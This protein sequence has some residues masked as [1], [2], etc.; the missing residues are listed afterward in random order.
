MN[1]NW[2]PFRQVNS[3]ERQPDRR[4][5]TIF[6]RTAQNV[7]RTTV[8]NSLTWLFGK[9]TPWVLITFFLTGI[10]ALA[11]DR[12]FQAKPRTC[13]IC[14]FQACVNGVED[15]F[16][17]IFFPAI[18]GLHSVSEDRWSR[19]HITLP[20]H[21]RAPPLSPSI[22]TQQTHV[23]KEYGGVQTLENP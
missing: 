2:S 18:I 8:N 1:W 13:A 7:A 15:V 3:L 12:H 23:K 22:R 4:R 20:S 5:L 14:Q 9:I 19:L 10:M 21:G 17:L 16:S 11:M 6:P